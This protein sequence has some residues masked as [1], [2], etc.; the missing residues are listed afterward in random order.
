MVKNPPANAGDTIRDMGLIPGSGRSSGGGHG[1]L[2]QY[3]CKE[4]PM[5]RGL[6]QDT[7]YGVPKNWTDWSDLICTD[8]CVTTCFLLK[9]A[10]G[11]EHRPWWQPSV[12]SLT[13]LTITV[14]LGH[15]SS[16]QNVGNEYF[17][18]L[19]ERTYIIIWPVQYPAQT[20]ILSKQW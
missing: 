5:D 1:N 20:V 6:W 12:W 16:L 9:K 17:R 15:I 13:P 8:T 11:K 2:L 4:N 10:S 3:S 14:C 19:F 18:K 7:V